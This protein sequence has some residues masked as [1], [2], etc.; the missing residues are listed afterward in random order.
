M[1]VEDNDS[2]NYAAGNHPHDEVEVGSHL[3]WKN[4]KNPHE[5]GKWGS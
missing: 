4:M 2:E 1:I 5:M 3:K